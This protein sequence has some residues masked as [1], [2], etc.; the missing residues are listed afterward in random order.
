M[1]FVLL[2]DISQNVKALADGA[3]VETATDDF[4]YEGW[5][6]FL[7][8]SETGLSFVIA[9]AFL[10]ETPVGI[11]RQLCHQGALRAPAFKADS[12]FLKP[13]IVRSLGSIVRSSAWSRN[14]R[15][16]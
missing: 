14:N 15:A 5:D 6:V 3:D 12:L 4:L 16:C 2:L 7:R 11:A 1:S 13:Y 9:P 10:S 8:I